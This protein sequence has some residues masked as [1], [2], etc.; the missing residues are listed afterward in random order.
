MELPYCII[1]D[2]QQYGND[3]T[4]QQTDTVFLTISFTLSCTVYTCI[5]C[6]IHPLLYNIYPFIRSVT[7]VHSSIDLARLFGALRTCEPVRCT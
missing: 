7:F 5:H 2:N 4:V 1:V 6:V 3:E